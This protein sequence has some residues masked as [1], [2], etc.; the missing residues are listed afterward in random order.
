[1]NVRQID[2]KDNE[3]TISGHRTLNATAIESGT[4]HGLLFWWVLMMDSEGDIELSTAPKWID[5]K[6]NQS[7]Q[8]TDTCISMLNY[9][10]LSLILIIA[11]GLV[12]CSTLV[13]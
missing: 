3:S 9:Y 7:L 6:S 1:M 8:V 12:S 11:N 2:G 13:A 10:D 5:T 4:C